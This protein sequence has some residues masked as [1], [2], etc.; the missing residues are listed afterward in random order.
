MSEQLHE[1]KKSPPA[2]LFV[3][4]HM[5]HLAGLYWGHVAVGLSPSG[6]DVVTYT[7]IFDS[8]TVSFPQERKLLSHE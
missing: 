1:Q 2:T 6:G 7:M 5:F 4:L 3:S 8:I